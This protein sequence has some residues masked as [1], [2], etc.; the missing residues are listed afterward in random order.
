MLAAVHQQTQ[1]VYYPPAAKPL[2]P[3]EGLGTLHLFYRVDVPAWRALPES[4]RKQALADLENLVQEARAEPRTTIVTL[5]MLARADLGFMIL[6]PD[7]QALN[8]LE[9]KIT[10]S[11][12]PNVLVPEF[13]Y[14]SL[15]ERSEYTQ[16]DEDYAL[17]LEQEQKIMRGTPESEAK[18]A[19]FR[20]RIAL[21]R[22]ERLYPNL[23]PWEYFCFYPMSKR[24][25]GDAELVRA[26]FRDAAPAHGRPH[27]RGP[28]LRRPRPPA[29][30][31]LDRHGRLGVGRL[32]LRPRSGRHQ[33]D[34][35]RDALRRGLAHSTR[36]SARSST[37]CRCPCAT[38]TRGCSFQIETLSASA[39]AS[40]T[41]RRWFV[42]SAGGRCSSPKLKP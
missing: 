16:K 19:E 8:A 38:S 15:T 14:L 20:E 4:Q 6:M 21:Y 27:A 35:L 3:A 2:R 39:S 18:V 32:A 25:R 12:G 22:H 34:R 37:A 42:P 29:R 28:H 33:G 41:R 36:N 5:S 24:A 23:P 11:L 1:T 40:S 9:K 30:H 17:E 7:L 10:A 31:R 26:R 13:S